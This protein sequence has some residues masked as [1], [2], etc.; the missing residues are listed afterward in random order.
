M[1]TRPTAPAVL[2]MSSSCQR[3][4][5]RG[6]VT[7]MT[8]MAL[9][10]AGGKGLGPQEGGAAGPVAG[11]VGGAGRQSGSREPDSEGQRGG[12]DQQAGQQCSGGAQRVFGETV[13]LAAPSEVGV[14]PTCTPDMSQPDGARRTTW[15]QLF[16]RSVAWSG[17]ERLYARQEGC[18]GCE[19][20]FN[21][22]VL[23]SDRRN[24][25]HRLFD[26]AKRRQPGDYPGRQ[27]L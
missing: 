8:D 6:A 19:R 3:V 4:R 11:G 10:F 5:G 24:I 1:K 21:I 20:P 25:V 7:F 15:Y 17:R 18:D 23:L 12:D 2:A 13:H 27:I 22:G 26:I 9:A 14:G 16:R